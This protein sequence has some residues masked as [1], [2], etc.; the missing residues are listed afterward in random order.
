MAAGR[1]PFKP[2]NYDIQKYLLPARLPGIPRRVYP[3][4]N[5]RTES[6]KSKSLKY[7]VFTV[8]PG[9]FFTSTTKKYMLKCL[10]TNCLHRRE[11]RGSKIFQTEIG[12]IYSWK[13]S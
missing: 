4:G 11:M 10:M 8:S 2:G 9:I 1:E 7:I 5:T 6:R 3:K 12:Y 13:E